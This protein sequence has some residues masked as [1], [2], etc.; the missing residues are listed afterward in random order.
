MLLQWKVKEKGALLGDTSYG[1][2]EVFFFA[3]LLLTE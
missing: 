1:R 2:F 3:Y